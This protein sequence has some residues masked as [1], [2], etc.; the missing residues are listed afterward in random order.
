M[1]RFQKPRESASLAA[2]RKELIELIALEKKYTIFSEYWL[3]QREGHGLELARVREFDIE[4][5]PE[6]ADIESFATGE[7][8]AV[9][10]QAMEGAALMI[11]ADVSSSMTYYPNNLE[12]S[13]GFIRDI[14]VSLLVSSAHQMM[15][16]VGL[17]LFSD[18]VERI[19]PPQSG[20][21]ALYILNQFL[22]EE[23][24]TKG[25]ATDF[26]CIKSHVTGF[27]EAMICIVSDFQDENTHKLWLADF[28]RAE[29]DLVPV[30]IR[31]PLEKISFPKGAQLLCSNPE[32]GKK[33]PLYISARDYALMREEA[34]RHCEKVCGLFSTLRAE[35]VILDTAD[36]S[37]CHLRLKQ[38]FARKLGNA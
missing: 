9:V 15:S 17:V 37:D 19:F 18:K 27:Q 13:K 35:P 23:P 32:T 33:F 5:D 8:D 30:I 20:E 21:Y 2:R 34:D 12:Y 10:L 4:D 38:F 29:L 26:S 3:S 31:D 22:S 7:R 1:K 25:A 6:D 14:A 16:P 24:K 28:I 11:F 36:I